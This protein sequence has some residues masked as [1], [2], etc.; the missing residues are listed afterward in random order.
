MKLSYYNLPVK[1]PHLTYEE[2]IERYPLL[3]AALQWVLIGSQ[4]EAGCVIRDYR[5]G[6]PFSCE[7]CSHS[8]LT[9][10]DRIK[11]ASSAFVRRGV[12]ERRKRSTRP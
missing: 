3:V 8:G 12:R 1:E 2:C 7:A 4:S 5:D 11:H 6:L 10:L 9:P